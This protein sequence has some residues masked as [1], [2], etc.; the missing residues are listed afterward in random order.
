MQNLILGLLPVT[1]LAVKVQNAQDFGAEEP[2]KNVVE[3]LTGE[4]LP[5]Y[6]NTDNF[7]AKHDDANLTKAEKKA[8]KKADKKADKKAAK[9][10]AKAEQELLEEPEVVFAD[11]D[12][13]VVENF[14]DELEYA[15]DFES[16]EHIFNSTAELHAVHP[17]AN[18]TMFEEHMTWY[19][20]EEW[21]YSEY[22]SECGDKQWADYEA[23]G[24]TLEVDWD[25]CYHVDYDALWSA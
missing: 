24:Y 10:A 15:Y 17:D 7:G 5:Q 21:E 14:N 8:A 13:Y 4:D 20:P 18:L 12:E 6:D 22:D 2:M 16:L 19:R 23:S 25:A 9:K 1:C 11:V 3:F